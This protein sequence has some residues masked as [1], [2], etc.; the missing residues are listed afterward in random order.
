MKK[1]L[2]LLMLLVGNSSAYAELTVIADLGGESAVRFYESI[3]P[4]HSANAPVHPNAVPAELNESMLLPIVSHKWE[5]GKVEAKPVN[6]PGALPIFLIGADD[7]SKQWLRTRYDDLVK[8]QATGLVIN[9]NT[10]DEL[11]ELRQLAPELSLMPVS[12]DGLADRI[13][14]HHYPLLMTE[15]LISQ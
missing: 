6:L 3:Q 9:V 14:I 12:A 10:T 7:I 8:L 15:T 5:V 2:L 11:T 1:S 13:G 4:V